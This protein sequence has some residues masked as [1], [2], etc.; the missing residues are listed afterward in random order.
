MSILDR[1][2]ARQ[3]LTNIILLFVVLFA[4][5]VVIDFSLN[6][7]EFVR[8]ARQ[9]GKVGDQDPSTLRTGVLAVFLVMDLW[10]PRLF[11]LFG[12]MLGLVLVGAMGFTCTQLVKHRELVAI[13]AGGQS[14]HR[15]A[16]PLVL[17]AAGLLLLQAANREFILPRLAPLLTRDKQDAGKRELGMARRQLAADGHGRLFYARSFDLDKGVIDG[18]WVWE[19]DEQGLMTRLI[20]AGSARWANGS[21]RLT[22]GQAVTREP[23]TG[24]G[25]ALP[26]VPVL[27]IQTDLDP[28][29][30]KLRRYE[31]FKQN[32]SSS[33]A[34]E[35]I[36][37]YRSQPNPQQSRIDAIERVR[38]GRYAELG[39]TLL[40]LLVA[41]PFF[42]RREPT[43]MLVQSLFAAPV[44]IILIVG[45]V[46]GTTAA[47]SG[48][49]PQI[50][51]FLPVVAQIPLALAALTSI[52]T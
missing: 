47:I 26:P 7:D 22:D 13:L 44:A 3:Y 35:L 18:L 25:Q 15:V 37:R 29:A 41:L 4:F 49:P 45:G 1:Y 2:I 20:T 17:V 50:A 52:R 23:N 19:R 21:W 48:F 12:Y 42:L 30:L 36:A 38:W 31:S 27:S 40:T 8:S 34:G 33:Q 39:A 5:V 32:L 46:L 6:F 28:T 14:L 11:M 51:V 10:W 16:R 43:N 24:A 9:M